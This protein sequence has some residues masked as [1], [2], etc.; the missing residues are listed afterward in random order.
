MDEEFNYINAKL[1][2]EHMLNATVL[3]IDRTME[4]SWGGLKKLGEV[5][6]RAL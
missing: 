4:E 5:S 1:L 3:A 6:Q 2:K